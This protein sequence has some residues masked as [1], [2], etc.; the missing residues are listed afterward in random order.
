MAKT[1][2]LGY[3]LLYLGVALAAAWVTR[4]ALIDRCLDSGGRWN[5]EALACQ[6]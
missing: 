4:E 5:A 1:R 3:V 6:H 2:A